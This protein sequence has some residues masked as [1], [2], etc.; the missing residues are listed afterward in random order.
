MLTNTTK[1]R[2]ALEQERLRPPWVSGYSGSLPGTWTLQCVARSKID[3]SLLLNHTHRVRNLTCWFYSTVEDLNLVRCRLHVVAEGAVGF[4]AQQLPWTCAA[5][6]LCYREQ[7]S[8]E[9]TD[10]D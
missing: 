1:G 6:R 2:W 9:R 10:S 7:S 3:V 5:A 4:A 8:A